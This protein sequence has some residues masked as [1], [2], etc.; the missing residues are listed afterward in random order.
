MI[1]RSPVR[2]TLLATL[3]ICATL[4]VVAVASGATTLSVATPKN[5]ALAYTKKKLIAAHGK[6]TI[7]MLN[8]Q[9]LKHDIA[10]KASKKAK[11][12]IVKGQLVGKGKTSKVTATLK[13]G[14]YIF[15]CTVAGH[16][17]GGMWGTLVVK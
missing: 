14:T 13:K 7:K 1:E 6:V 10:I 17:A 16:E 3:A 5:G 8:T 11:K 2:R 9:L 12:P 15:Y 4:V